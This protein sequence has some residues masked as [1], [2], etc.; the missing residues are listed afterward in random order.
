MSVLTRGGAHT[1]DKTGLWTRG[2]RGGRTLLSAAM[3]WLFA[4]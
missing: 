1:V 2:T 4:T 3:G